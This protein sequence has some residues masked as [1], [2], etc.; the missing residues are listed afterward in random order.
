MKNNA[1]G[2]RLGPSSLLSLLPIA[3]YCHRIVTLQCDSHY[4]SSLFSTVSVSVSVSVFM[5]AALEAK[6]DEERLGFQTTRM[7]VETNPAFPSV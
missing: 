6:A 3:V 5:S 7:H 4:A 1:L 2:Q